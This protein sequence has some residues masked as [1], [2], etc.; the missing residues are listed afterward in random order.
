[1][2]VE[3]RGPDG[4][5]SP[6]KDGNDRGGNRPGSFPIEIDE[7]VRCEYWTEIRGLPDQV[8]ERVTYG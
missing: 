5:L 2:Y 8:D 6:R 4:C 7:D 3:A 1:M